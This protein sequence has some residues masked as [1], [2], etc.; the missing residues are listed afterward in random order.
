MFK[1]IALVLNNKKIMLRIAFTFL[2]LFIFKGLT[3]ITIPLINFDKAQLDTTGFFEYLN[4]FGGGA[5][6]R[7]SIVALGISPYITASIVVQMLQMDIV[8]LF[9]EWGEQGELGKR[10]LNNMTKYIG[11]GLTFIQALGLLIGL[12]STAE[13]PLRPD[14]LDTNIFMYIYM[15]LTVTAG[16]AIVIWL[17]DLITRRGVGNGSSL[18]ISAGI[19]SAIPTMFTSLWTQF[20]K[21][22]SSTKNTIFFIIIV[23]LYILVILGV[24]YMQIAV[25]KIPIQYANRQG[26]SDSNLPIKLNTAGVIPVIF[27]STL[28]SIPL[29]LMGMLSTDPSSGWGLWLNRIFNQNEIIGMILYTILIIVFAFFYTFLQVNPEKM[30]DNLKKSKA[31]IPGIREGEETTNFIAKILFRVT[32]LGTIYLVLLALTPIILSMIFNLSS[33]VSIGGTSLLIVVGVAVETTKQVETEA[34]EKTYSGF[35]R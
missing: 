19:L 11:I 18:I 9:K 1:K 12:G 25:R 34:T 20:I 32:V 33:A 3:Y 21:T 31:F 5:L 2:I 17:A 7:I 14:V 22:D 26:K 15:A 16:S 27:A 4:T 6:E 29:T 28:M 13:S 23:L 30:A 8:P 24:V 10:K 35:I